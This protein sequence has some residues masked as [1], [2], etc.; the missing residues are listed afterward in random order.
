MRPAVPNHPLTN[1]V[2]VGELPH[3]TPA[4][5]IV[6]ATASANPEGVGRGSQFI[7]TAAHPSPH[8]G[9]HTDHQ[10]KVRHIMGYHCPGPNHRP[11]PN[12]QTRQN[13]AVGTKR[14]PFL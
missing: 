5:L 2:A 1:P 14:T 13:R 4:F 3:L 8:P 7:S 10:T 9:G 6:G 12:G 11:S